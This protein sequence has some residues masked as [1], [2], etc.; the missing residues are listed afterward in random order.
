[1]ECDSDR[2]WRPIL[3][4]APDESIAIVEQ[5]QQKPTAAAPTPSLS[6][7]DALGLIFGSSEV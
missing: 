5:M 2:N 4:V 6:K 7:A 1:M 3:L